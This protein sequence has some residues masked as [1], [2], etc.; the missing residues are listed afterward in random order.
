MSREIKSTEELLLLRLGRMVK[1]NVEL[2]QRVHQLTDDF[3]EVARQLRGQE[4]R[5]DE[6]PATQMLGEMSQMRYR[7]DQLELE[8]EHLN[9]YAKAFDSFIKDKELYMPKGISCPYLQGH[10]AVASTPCLECD[11]CL[12]VLDDCGVVCRQVLYG[13]KIGSTKPCPPHPSNS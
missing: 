2:E 7:C 8:N 9:M 11:S 4:K 13:A 10:L 1:E 12:R 3:N 6:A 5:K